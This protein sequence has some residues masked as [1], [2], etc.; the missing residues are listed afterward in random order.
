MENKN[1]CNYCVGDDPIYYKD[2]DNC[3]FI[4]TRGELYMSIS[5]KIARCKVEFC[6]KCGRKFDELE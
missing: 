1:D 3:A 4:D 2:N 6:P 5:G